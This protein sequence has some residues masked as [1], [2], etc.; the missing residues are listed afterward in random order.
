MEE[1]EVNSVKEKSPFRHSKHL[2]ELSL[3][4]IIYAINVYYVK[5]ID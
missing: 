1:R 3:F 4:M 5:V 2:R